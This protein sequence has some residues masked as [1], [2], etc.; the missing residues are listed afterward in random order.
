MTNNSILQQRLRK[1]PSGLLDIR[2]DLQHFALINYTVPKSRLEPF[3][4]AERFEIMA[5]EIN[6]RN[7][8]MLSVVPFVDADFS[9][10][11][12]CSWFKSRFSQTNHRVYVIDKETSEPV[13]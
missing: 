1:R 5:F 2:S 11:R 3:I 13:V 8:A 9:F 6:G 12:L 10:Y 7:Q 4:P